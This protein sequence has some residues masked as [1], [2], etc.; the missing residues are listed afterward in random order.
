MFAQK[1]YNSFFLK[2]KV[3][4][5]KREFSKRYFLKSSKIHS[6]LHFSCRK[7]DILLQTNISDYD[8]NVEVAKI[9]YCAIKTILSPTANFEDYQVLFI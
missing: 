8:F 3:L 2:Y 6:L 5:S 1:I 7:N 9:R 4:F